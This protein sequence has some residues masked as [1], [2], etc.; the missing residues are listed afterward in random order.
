[1][2][3]Q[4]IFSWYEGDAEVENRSVL[5]MYVSAHSW[6]SNLTFPQVNTEM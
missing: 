2:Y 6:T 4:M 1:M 5:K 3:G